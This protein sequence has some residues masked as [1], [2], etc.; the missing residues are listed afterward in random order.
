MG[1]FQGKVEC[2]DTLS[3]TN[4]LFQYDCLKYK[5]NR[6]VQISQWLEEIL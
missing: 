5:K 6:Q 2:Y 1:T 4:I 3:F